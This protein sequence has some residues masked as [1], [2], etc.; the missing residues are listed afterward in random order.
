M[1]A[2]L[3]FLTEA[4]RAHNER[5]LAL[6]LRLETQQIALEGLIAERMRKTA[7]KDYALAINAGLIT[8]G[9]TT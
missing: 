3:K 7:P 4:M 1:Q 5:I 8:R 9:E 6:E 2:I